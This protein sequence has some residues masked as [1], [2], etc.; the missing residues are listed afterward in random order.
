AFIERL[1]NDATVSFKTFRDHEELREFVGN[2][3]AVLL[4]ERFVTVVDHG[5]RGAHR[6]SLP[7]PRDA[8]VGRPA[9]GD[10]IVELLSRTTRLVTVTGPGGVGKTRLVIEAGRRSD[11]LFVDG[12][13]F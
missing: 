6:T 12:V 3:L 9:E 8:F 7:A 4:T 11:E 2:D 1:M 13:H 10:A 5:L